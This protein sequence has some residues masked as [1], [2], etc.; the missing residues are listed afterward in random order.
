ML[1]A[2]PGLIPGVSSMYRLCSTLDFVV[3][4]SNLDTGVV[5]G[6]IVAT[7]IYCS[8][9]LVRN[10]PPNCLSW[11]NGFLMSMARTLPGILP[12]SPGVD[13]I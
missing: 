5:I 11:V 7:I 8:A 4:H 9:D 12:G 13:M 6:Y 3:E 10:V 1:G 2:V